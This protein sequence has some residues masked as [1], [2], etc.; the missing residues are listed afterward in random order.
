MPHL[1]YPEWGK[2]AS[3]GGVMKL[4]LLAIAGMLFGVCLASTAESDDTLKLTKRNYQK[5]GSEKA[6]LLVNINWRRIWGC[7]TT[8]Y[9]Q[10][11]KLEFE[12]LVE[13]FGLVK[14]GPK[15]SLNGGGMLS[16]LPEGYQLLV[17]PGE[18]ALVGAEIRISEGFRKGGG[19]LKMDK[20][21]L[22]E[23]RKP[24]GGG[25][26]V[27]QG[28][29]V[30]IGDFSLDCHG[31]PIPWRYY[32]T[33][34]EGFPEFVD[35]LLDRHPYLDPAAIQF[36]LFESKHFSQ[37]YGLMQDLLHRENADDPDGDLHIP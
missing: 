34:A 12:R 7:G 6:V 21:T 20:E 13:P 23:N 19:T 11:R 37:P 28:E 27:N 30:Y 18:Y 8:E 14:D 15:I 35:Y 3:G 26:T 10:L 1:D 2:N 17:E 16:S 9:A 5:H 32:L 25:F 33:K 36:R 29:I 24:L 31:G 22:V 4:F